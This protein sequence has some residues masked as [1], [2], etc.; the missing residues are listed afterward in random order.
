MYGSSPLRRMRYRLD[1]L[2]LR[3]RMRSSLVN[4]RRS[5]KPRSA[6]FC[7]L[8]NIKAVLIETICAPKIKIIL[9]RCAVPTAHSYFPLRGQLLDSPLE[10]GLGGVIGETIS[11]LTLHP[12]GPSRGQLL[13]SPLEPG[14]GGVIGVTISH[15]TLH[16]CGPLKGT[17]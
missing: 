2:T 8:L 13:D 9:K 14:Q 6:S 12:C 7:F 3:M 10:G 1:S 16:P 11:H 5:A 17:I 4:N 15:L